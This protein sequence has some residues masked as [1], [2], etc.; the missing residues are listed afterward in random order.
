MSSSSDRG[1]PLGDALES[2]LERQGYKRRLDQASVIPEWEKLVGP[3]ISKVTA[4]VAVRQDGTLL[5]S[6][7]SSA[8]MQELQMMSPEILRK[9]GRY[10]KKIRRIHWRLE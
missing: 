10:R 8:W 6:V 2:Y 9:L 1:A 7:Q 5:V 4:P 3:Q